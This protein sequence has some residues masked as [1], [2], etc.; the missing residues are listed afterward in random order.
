MRKIINP[1]R[2]LFMLRED[3]FTDVYTPETIQEIQCITNN[4]GCIH[5]EEAILDSPENYKDVEIVFSGWGAP[6]LTDEFLNS[7]PSLKAIFYAAGTVKPFITNAFWE[8]DIILTSAFQAN[9][10]PVAEFTVATITLALKRAWYFNRL[11]INGIDPKIKDHVIP[12]SYKGT[13]VGIISLG[14][15]GYLV[16]EKLNQMDVDVLAYD[17]YVSEDVFN[18]LGVKRVDSLESIFEQSNVVSLH[19]P[20]L[21]ETENMITGELLQR[22][23]QDATF[24]NTARPAIVNEPNLLEVL[25]Q[26]P[27]IQAILDVVDESDSIVHNPL[28]QMANAFITPHI[29]GSMGRECHRMGAMALQECYRFL[30]GKPQLA[31]ISRMAT[32]LIA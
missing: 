13:R 27:D 2:S 21:K 19:A 31:P 6:R 17:P 23:P 32:S 29:A 18:Q 9:A 14:A 12:G 11:L 24:I 16:C 4:D 22:L 5:K 28:N 1:R 10:I 20:W 8:R 26:R 3:I 25:K 30:A 7:L 15:I